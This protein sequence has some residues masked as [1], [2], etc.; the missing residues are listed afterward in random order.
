MFKLCQRFANSSKI[1][2]DQATRANKS[3]FNNSLSSNIFQS[4][5]PS[6]SLFPVAKYSAYTSDMNAPKMIVLNPN[7]YNYIVSHSVTE[8][9]ILK[10]LR[11][12]TWTTLTN[13]YME[14][15]PDEGALLQMLIRLM[16]A[17]KCLEVGTF[18]GY[19]S[20]A[21]AMALPDDGKIICCDISEEYTNIAKKYWKE[22]NVD[23]KVELRIAPAL[24]TLD[25]L[26]DGGHQNSF[27]YAFIDADKQNLEHY[28]EKCLKL[29]R[30]GGLIAVDNVL[31]E[32]KVAN[33]AVNDAVT[34]IIK[35]FNDK[36]AQD[37]R[38]YLSMLP[39]SDGLTLAYKK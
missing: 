15:S 35:K 33:D 34:L 4:S 10:K 6:H 24:D 21:V 11:E 23:H 30:Q 36:L 27:D 37:K 31:W 32:G 19:S 20:L 39:V 3:F 18:T 7:L 5:F 22:A 9:P 12:E 29:V 13:A 2:I 26:I 14:I 1:S 17:K 25:K 8:H 16:N 28:F 38:V